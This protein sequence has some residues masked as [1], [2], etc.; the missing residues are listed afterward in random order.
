MQ[1]FPPKITFLSDGSKAS[2]VGE[3]IPVNKSKAGE[4]VAIYKF[5]KGGYL[6]EKEVP[7]TLAHIQRLCNDKM[8]ETK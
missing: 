3:V 7:I 4:R 2:L 6:K 8:L 5:T 1:D